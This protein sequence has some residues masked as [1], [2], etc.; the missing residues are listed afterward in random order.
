MSRFSRGPADP[1]GPALDSCRAAVKE[2]GLEF[3]LATDRAVEDLLYSNV[4]AALW[5]CRYGIAI[6]EDRV[7]EGLNYNVMFEV[8]A[9]LVTGRPCLILKD[10]SIKKL[11]TDL[12][13]HIYSEVDIAKPK[14]ITPAVLSWAKD[15]LEIG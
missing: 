2:A 14:S 13:G 4:A 9:M 6:I 8:G 15:R 11:P 12:I 7:E 1:I 10:R 3:H 5:A